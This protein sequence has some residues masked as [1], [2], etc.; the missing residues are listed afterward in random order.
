MTSQLPRRFV[1]RD[2]GSGRVGVWDTVVNAWRSTNQTRPDAERDAAD[3]ELRFDAWGIRPAHTIRPVTPA[4]DVDLATWQPAGLLDYWIRVRTEASLVP[5]F[6]WYGRI[7]TPETGSYRWLPAAELRR[8][9][10][11]EDGAEN[12]LRD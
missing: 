11:P 10:G 9:V 7:R 2:T 8:S 4:I 1:I 3:L 12:E 6:A 5:S